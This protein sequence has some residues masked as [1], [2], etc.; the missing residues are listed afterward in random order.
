MWV[1]GVISIYLI[2]GNAARSKVVVLFYAVIVVF[3]EFLYDF[4][5]ICEYVKIGKERF[6]T[7]GYF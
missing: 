5:R 3:L 6:G 7:V 1:I 2:V 4:Y